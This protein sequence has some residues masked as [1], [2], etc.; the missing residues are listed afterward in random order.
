[1]AASHKDLALKLEDLEQKY[2][3]QFAVF[4]EAILQM[5][6]P[7]EKGRKEIGFRVEESG[8]AYV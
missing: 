2:D 7:E 1:M 3:K 6:T 8:G 4:F 5:M